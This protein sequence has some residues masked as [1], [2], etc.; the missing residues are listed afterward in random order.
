MRMSIQQ[1][2]QSVWF[3]QSLSGMQLNGFCVEK[4]LVHA[5]STEWQKTKSNKTAFSKFFILKNAMN[6]SVNSFA[7]KN[8]IKSLKQ[9]SN[10]CNI[11]RRFFWVCSN[12]RQAPPKINIK[13]MVPEISHELFKRNVHPLVCMLRFT[14]DV[15]ITSYQLRH[16]ENSEKC[17]KQSQKLSLSFN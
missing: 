8:W 10:T 2:R 6:F 5:S 4:S 1:K 14:F 3:F 13:K 15:N 7:F 17:E 11:M 16:S 9:K 12:F